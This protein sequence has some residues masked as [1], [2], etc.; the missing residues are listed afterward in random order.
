MLFAG[1]K[2]IEHLPKEVLF[3]YRIFM[4]NSFKLLQ[5]ENLILSFLKKKIKIFKNFKNFNFNSNFQPLH[6][7]GFLKSSD[8]M[9]IFK[10]MYRPLPTE[11]KKYQ[12]D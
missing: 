1:I 10:I 2:F 6:G 8:N 4:T 11:Q 5:K 12:Q 7:L 3:I 9:S